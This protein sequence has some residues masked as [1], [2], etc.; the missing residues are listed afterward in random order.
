[1]LGCDYLILTLTVQMWVDQYISS[2]LCSRHGEPSTF[3]KERHGGEKQRF[4]QFYPKI[5]LV[6]GLER[7]IV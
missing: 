4:V 2:T 1:M 7:N 6:L 5:Y 3:G